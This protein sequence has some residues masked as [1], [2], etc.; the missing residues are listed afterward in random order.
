[1]RSK[2][3]SKQNTI[4]RVSLSMAKHKVDKVKQEPHLSGAYIRSLVKHLTT[5]KTKDSFNDSEYSPKTLNAN[6]ERCANDHNNLHPQSPPPP[7]PKKQVRRRQHTRKPYQER[8]LNMAEARKEIVTAL[9]FHRAS[10]QQESADKDDPQLKQP[11]LEPEEKSNNK[12][13]RNPRAYP[14]TT[15][16]AASTNAASAMNL[17]TSY[18][19]GYPSLS[20]PP[21]NPYYWPISTISPPPLPPL[22][23]ASLNPIL[24]NQTLGLNLNYHDF[25]NLDAS[26]YHNPLSN[27]STSSSSSCSSSSSAAVSASEEIVTNS[28]TTSS[29]GGYDFHQAMDDEE[30]KEIISLGEQHQME[31]N[32]TMNLVISARWFDYLKSIDIGPDDKSSCEHIMAFPPCMDVGEFE[33]MDG[34]W[35]A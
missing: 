34:E 8:L 29:S 23:H 14:S 17:S 16:A 22:Y 25:K 13:R 35:L 31:W 30:M 9:K 7:P 3:S 26:L 15:T 5:T 1:M 32:D 21:S 24:P 33:G 28:T 19:D 12:C 6:D 10:K 4:N 20:C 11:S 18:L 2:S 27:Y